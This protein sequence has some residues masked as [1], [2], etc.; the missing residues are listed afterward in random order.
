MNV[1]CAALYPITRY[2]FPYSLDDYLKAIAEMRSAGFDACELE[3]NVDIDLVDYEQRI[4]Q[5]KQA[6]RQNDMKLSAVIGVVNGAFSMDKELADEYL[7][8]F[9]RLCTFIENV[10]CD[11]ACICAYMPPEIKG[12]PGS[13]AYRGSPPLQVRVPAGFRW[14]PF[15]E[16]A[17]RR[18]AQMARICAR[19]GQRLVIENRVGDFVSTSDGVLRLLDDA[20]EANAGCLLDLAHTHASKEHFDL[21]IPK[22]RRRLMYVHLADND[23]TFS[24]HLP[25]G[26]GNIDFPAVFLS[27]HAVGYDGYVNVDYGGVPPDQILDEVKKGRQFFMRCLAEINEADKRA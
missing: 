9:E 26:R 22:L 1:G 8:K 13:E 16:N 2:G 15:W 21:V 18:L 12:V 4:G 7:R 5:V 10:G 6:L 3:I 27:L 17:T 23:G 20:G 24:Y 25:A 19:H 11:T 14:E